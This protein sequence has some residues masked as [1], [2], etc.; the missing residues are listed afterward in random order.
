VLCGPAR[1]DIMTSGA[2]RGWTPADTSNRRS[3][4]RKATALFVGLDLHKD[5]ISIAHAEA[6]GTDPPVSVGSIGSWQADIDKLVRKLHSKA[7]HLVLAY[8][9][10]PS[11]YVLHRYLTA[12]GLDCR[13]VAPSLAPKRPDDKVKNDRRDAVEIARLLRSGDL[14]NIYVPGIEDEAV[15]D[16]C[17]ARDRWK[18]SRSGGF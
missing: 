11:G 7:A 2:K 4:I 12:K 5:F 16:V 14:T 15:R 13:V 8:E 6:H 9:A 1:L 3:A 10:G 18:L 17:R